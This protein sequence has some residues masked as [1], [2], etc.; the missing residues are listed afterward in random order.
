M[1]CPKCSNEMKET[2]YKGIKY[3]QCK[4]CGGLW[5][6]ALEAE[7]LVEISGSVEIDTGDVRQGAEYNKKR[8]IECPVCNVRM[9]KVHD[10]KQP[11]IKLE[12][13]GVCHGTFF[14]AGEFK[15]FSEE[16]F[17]DGIKDRLAKRH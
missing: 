1:Q 2:E 15:D 16:T 5:F 9:C 10:R 3:D 17:M 4:N 7:E 8:L 11:H 6:D 13:C 12:T 14:D